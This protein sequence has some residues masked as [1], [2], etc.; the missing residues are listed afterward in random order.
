[1]GNPLRFTILFKIQRE[2]IWLKQKV[3]GQLPELT[4]PVKR[5]NQKREVSEQYDILVLRVDLAA[6]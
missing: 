1:M 2:K 3:E 4:L 5:E 6:N